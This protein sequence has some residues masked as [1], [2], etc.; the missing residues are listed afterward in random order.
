MKQAGKRTST[1]SRLLWLRDLHAGGDI[2]TLLVTAV[3]T[4]LLVRFVLHITGYPQ[5]GGASLHIAH[6]LWGGLLMMVAMVILVSFVDRRSRSLAVIVGG[7]GFGLFVDEAGKFL[8]Q[9][10]NYF[11]RP[12]VAIIYVTFVA[13]VLA[14]RAVQSWRGYRPEE[15]LADALREVREMAV[16]DLDEPERRHALLALERS[17]PTHPLVPVLREALIASRV[18]PTRPPSFVT[19]WRQAARDAYHRVVELPAF[20]K[21]LVILFAGQLLVRLIYVFLLVFFARGASH[22]NFRLLAR[23]AEKAEHLNAIEIAQIGSSL[24]SGVFVVTGIAI[25]PRSRLTAYGRFRRSVLVTI[26]VTQVFVF[27]EKQFAALV[28]LALNVLLLGA[29]DFMMERERSA[30]S[31]TSRTATAHS[32]QRGIDP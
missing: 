1:V 19:R 7:V 11:Y 29:L 14:A 30:L 26:L 24:V 10:N 27:Y 9:D 12:A 25:L 18:V 2:E 23:V 3:A 16:H 15:Y 32:P 4:V 21:G 6:V 17:D 8:T 31:A 22:W 5:L 28:G 13:V 20:T